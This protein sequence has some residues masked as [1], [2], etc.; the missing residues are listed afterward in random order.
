M[1]LDALLR[2]FLT[3]LRR[4]V[5]LLRVSLY[6]IGVFSLLSLLALRSLHAQ[7]T[8]GVRALGRQLAGLPELTQGS[9]TLEINGARMHFARAVT[10]EPISRVLDRVE[11]HCAERLGPFGEVLQELERRHPA[12]MK[13]RIPAGLRNGILRHDDANEGVLICLTDERTTGI[14][15]L[16]RAVPRFA[17]TWDLAEFGRFRYAFAERGEDGRTLVITTWSD[18]SLSL[19]RMFPATGDAAGSDSPVLPRPPGSRRILSAG[20]ERASM[21]VRLYET[22]QSR[23][24]V[25][26]FYDQWMSK[27]RWTRAAES[28]VDG[29]Q[30][31]LGPAGYQ[32]FLT[33]SEDGGGTIVSLLEAGT[34]DG[35]AHATL[36]V[37]KGKD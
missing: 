1:I 4:S 30:A 20:P 2:V 15:W 16:T 26:R 8:E 6:L 37:R 23:R 9:Q 13:E 33:V 19:A 3:N 29:T 10:L 11:K 22:R 25:E 5:R 36:Q 34:P 27:K 21:G 32:L 35:R 7:V 12:Q 28:E 17:E 31:F 18:D 24:E 14:D